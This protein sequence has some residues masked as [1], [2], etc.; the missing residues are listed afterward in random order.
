MDDLV[1]HIV[2]T[3][4]IIILVFL[5]IATYIDCKNYNKDLKACVASGMQEWECRAFLRR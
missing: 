4:I 3:V 2:A 1:G 5:C